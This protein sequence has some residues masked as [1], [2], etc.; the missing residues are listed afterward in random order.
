MNKHILNL[1]IGLAIVFTACQP[2]EKQT[3]I[4]ETDHYGTLANLPFENDF[5]TKE[6]VETLE[7]EV[8]FQR[9]VQVYHWALPAMNMYS[10]KEAV[11][12]E[13]GSGYEVLA[14]YKDR[15]NAKTII[16]TPNSDV[17]YG[18]GFLDLKADGPMV[19]DAPPMLQA[20]IDD[21]WHRPI[22]GPTIDGKKYSADIGLPGPDKGKGGKYLILPPD[23]SGD[24]DAKNYFVYNSRTNGV[25]VFLRSFFEDPN[26]LKPAAENMMRIKIYPYGKESEAKEMKFPNA[27][28]IPVNMVAPQDITY[29]EMLNRFVQNEVVDE[30]DSY[31]RG[32]LAAIG[33][34]KGKPF[35]PTDHQKELLND[36]A[37]TAWK[38]AKVIAFNTWETLPKAKW[39][40]DRQ[41]NSHIRDGGE[42]FGK[43]YD[44]FEFKVAGMEETDVDARLHMFLNAYSISPGMGS[45]TPGVGAKYLE[46]AKDSD[47]NF[48]DGGETYKLTLPANIPAKNFWSITAYD[49]VTAAGLDNGQA[50]PSLGSRDMPK[51]NEDGSTTIYFSP[52]APEGMEGNWVKTVPGK[53]W[54]TLLRLYGPEEAFF[55]K[56]WVPGD[57][58]KVE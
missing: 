25:F 19:I 48:L 58:E 37:Q 49:P 7:D 3:T 23:Y 36:A 41:W 16:T 51:K 55:D 8:Y 27:S 12:N 54:F 1:S 28:N 20:L 29:F 47:G 2:Q 22:D 50:F 44:D 14:V 6:T 4:A 39:Y 32:M 52:E 13:F 35:E 56:S 33:I 43:A 34:E 31:M 5:P 40:S 30:S 15:L 46:A 18:I 9:A 57:F 42:T 38:M 17:I 21:M 53:G 45:T 26:N 11:A 10:M 24:I